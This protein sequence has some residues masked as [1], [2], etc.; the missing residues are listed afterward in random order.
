MEM[1]KAPS[2]TAGLLFFYAARHEN[3]GVSSAATYGAIRQ[4]LSGRVLCARL[5]RSALRFRFALRCTGF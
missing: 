3:S 2:E 5:A 4:R 1:V